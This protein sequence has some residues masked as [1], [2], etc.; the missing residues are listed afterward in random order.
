MKFNISKEK[1]MNS[2]ALD[3]SVDGYHD[4]CPNEFFEKQI[5]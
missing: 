1:L 3:V 2:E 5:Y 4:F